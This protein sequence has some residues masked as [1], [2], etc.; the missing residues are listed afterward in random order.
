MGVV[1]WQGIRGGTVQQYTC[2]STGV[3]CNMLGK[4]LWVCCLPLERGLKG[5]E[6]QGSSGYMLLQ[7]GTTDRLLHRGVQAT[8]RCEEG[9]GTGHCKKGPRPG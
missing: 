2:S 1:L 4:G 8:G 9:Q 5:D 6:Q 3:C 7:T